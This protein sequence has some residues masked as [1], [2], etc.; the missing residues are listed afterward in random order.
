MTISIADEDLVRLEVQIASDGKPYLVTQDTASVEWCRPYGVHLSELTELVGRSI[1]L[2]WNERALHFYE[3]LEVVPEAPKVVL[4]ESPHCRVRVAPDGMDR[5]RPQPEEAFRGSGITGILSVNAWTVLSS[6]GSGM[7]LLRLRIGQHE[8]ESVLELQFPDQFDTTQSTIIRFD[9]MPTLCSAG[10]LLCVE[11][12][13]PQT[14]LCRL[15]GSDA[16][17]SSVTFELQEGIELRRES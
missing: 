5:F 13:H 4:R 10:F 11:R 12:D 7:E 2:P 3:L 1:A 15:T 16:N 9:K 6:A 17:A 8:G 14:P